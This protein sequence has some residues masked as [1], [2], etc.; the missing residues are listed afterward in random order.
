MPEAKGCRISKAGENQYYVVFNKC[1]K[2]I[3][4]VGQTRGEKQKINWSIQP[5]QRHVL[6]C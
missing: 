5:F 2:R 6:M 3:K 1:P 4:A